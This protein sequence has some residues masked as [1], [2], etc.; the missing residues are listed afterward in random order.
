MDPA[1]AGRCSRRSGTPNV[2][3]LL[4]LVLAAG[5][6]LVPAPAGARQ[7]S[8]RQTEQRLQRLREALKDAGRERQQVEGQ[9]SQA[10]ERVRQVEARIAAGQRAL[11]A[12]ERALAAQQRAVDEAERRYQSLQQHQQEQR[13]ALAEL[14]RGADRLGRQTPLKLLLSQQRVADGNRLLAYY[15]Y[16]QADQVRRLHA[17]ETDLQQLRQAREALDQRSATLRQTRARQQRQV[18]ELAAQRAERAQLLAQLERQYR[19]KAAREQALDRD[20]KA[21]AKV[22]ANLRAAAARAEAERREAA[23][24]AAEAERAA[25]TAG[26]KPGKPPAARPA[27]SGPKVGGLGWPV[28]GRLLAG[29][30]GRLPDGRRSSG[31]LIAAP[32]GTAVTAVADGRVVFSDWMTGYGN[33]LI[34]DHGNGYMSL[35]AHNDALLRA[36]GSQVRRGD[37]LARVGNSGGQG[38][39]AL[40]FELRRDGQPVDPATWLR[41]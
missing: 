15:R 9:R 4:L 5:M 30:G 18:R 12:T 35:Y 37:A 26:R 23:R 27:G 11:A 40:Y 29:Y 2:L 33:I 3:H 25:R 13:R 34:V 20:A 22:L 17:L 10:D 8:T 28:S 21:L 36:V 41:R 14:L 16:L 24:R 1:A 32:T 31:V 39:S 7:D 38:I 19:D 6:A